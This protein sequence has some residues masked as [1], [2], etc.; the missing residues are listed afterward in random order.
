MDLQRPERRCL[1]WSRAA[2]R[3]YFWLFSPTCCR[4]WRLLC[5]KAG[6]RHPTSGKRS[7]VS[8]PVI[9][10]VACRKYVWPQRAT[11]WERGG[12]LWAHVSRGSGMSMALVS[13]KGVE[14]IKKAICY[15]VLF[16]RAAIRYSAAVY[17]NDLILLS[18]PRY[19]FLSLLNSTGCLSFR[20]APASTGRA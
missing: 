3:R 14:S 11:G 6:T 18:V 5:C 13:A 2:S 16:R 12:F 4:L 15:S 7:Q 17:P 20:R 10:T 8:L 9:R 1:R 19:P